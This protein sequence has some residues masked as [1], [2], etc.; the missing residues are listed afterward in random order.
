MKLLLNI[1][2]DDFDTVGLLS[3]LLIKRHHR[4]KVSAK[5]YTI[6]S[7]IATAKNVEAEAIL[8]SNPETLKH[9]APTGKDSKHED[10]R[11]A[12]LNFSIPV[13]VISP[14]HHIVSVPE[15]EFLME[16]DLDKLNH[17]RLPTYKYDYTICSTVEK[18]EHAQQFLKDSYLLVADIET[19]R[20][21]T[22]TS[23]AFTEVN[24]K[25]QIGHTYC[26]PFKGWGSKKF[27][28]YALKVTKQ[29]IEGPSLKAFHNGMFDVFHLLRHGMAPNNYVWDTEYLW[30]SW[31]AELNKSLAFISSVLLP[32]YYYWKSEAESSPLEYNCKDTIN[33]ARCLLEILKKIP[34]WALRN[35]AKQF[36]M[37]V[38][39]IHSNFEGFKCNK[40][41]L[42]EL[43]AEAEKELEV[44]QE[45]LRV[46]S[47]TPKLNIG[48]PHQLSK[49]LYQ[50]LGAVKPSRTKSKL[51]TDAITLAKIALQHPLIARFVNEILKYRELSKIYSTYYSVKLLDGRILYNLN[52]DGTETGRLSGNKSSLYAEDG[53]SNYGL[54]IQTIP[55]NAR[56][57]FEADD[58][59]LLGE[60]DKS[61]SEARCTAYLSGDELLTEDLETPG[62]DF[63]CY[64]AFRFFTREI[65]KK[66]P[67]RQLVKK[68]VH[69]TNYR[70]QEDTFMD[71]VGLDTMIEMHKML[72]RPK[73]ESLRSFASYLLG[74]YT[75]TYVRVPVWWK[76][77]T[78]EA[79]SSGRIVTPD[80]WVRQ[81][82][83]NPQKSKE[84][85]RSLIAHK[86]QHLSVS[87]L[88]KAYIQCYYNLQVGS[89]GEFKLK[90][91]NHDS[92]LFQA[93]KD[94]FNY[95][96]GRVVEF[97]DI[98]I[99]FADGRI[100]KIPTDA[101]YGTN[102]KEMSNWD[103]NSA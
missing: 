72:N 39:L 17:I 18:V 16:T 52:V 33:T 78:L 87:V 84:I 20:Q 4:A 100:L 99:E 32:D 21:N 75:G 45:R 51:G 31:Q 65:D 9:I 7:L 47:A 83:G 88:N 46:M 59:Y 6:E 79:A 98:G 82:Y 42:G 2:P 95:Y 29:L 30:W 103:V 14:C 81:V 50:V 67:L 56:V 40:E 64:M 61:Q 54:P 94:K 53:V 27:L 36:P 43:R 24:S 85:E 93:T 22:I 71:N 28:E 15:G 80:G 86:P 63:Y 76:H 13:L 5:T 55:S 8:C 60:V 90:L 97:M 66:D 3:G 23:I 69:G 62:R 92:T 1:S 102:W 70:M 77:T 12:R 37:A 89:N 26:I 34:A 11:G 96:M 58:G 41:K 44:I 101:K 19:S 91:Q 73:S 57:I 35:Y 38:P 74:L 49:L 68:I 25:G 48:S 10:W